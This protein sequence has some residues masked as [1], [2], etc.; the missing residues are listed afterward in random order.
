MALSIGLILILG[1]L[2]GYLL[3]KIKIPGLTGMIIIGMLIGPYCLSLIDPSVLSIS[4]ELRQIA[5]IIILT[6]SGLNLDLDSLR[7]IGRPAIL[8]SFVPATLEILGVALVG[9][10]LLDI[11]IFE[12]I[13]LGT[14]LAAV[15]PAV[16]SP[17]MIKLIDEGYGD[18]HNTPKLILAGSSID[19]IYVIVLFYTFFGLVENNRFDVL[20]ISMIPVTIILGIAL[21]II[22][23]IVLSFILRKTNFTTAV[24]TLIVFSSS[25]LMVGLEAILKNYISIS[26]LLG[27]IVVGIIILFKNKEKAKSLSKAY[28]SLWLFFEIILFV[29]VGASVDFSYALDNSL[30]AILI[31]AVGLIFRSLGVLICLIKTNLNFKE[32]LFC[33]ISY[34]PKATVQASIGG[35]ALALNLSCG[36]IILTLAVTSILITAPIGAILIDNLSKKLLTNKLNN[37]QSV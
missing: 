14:V 2:I 19:D 26:A 23:G 3:S 17:R 30:K 22:V 24:N 16:V 32:R 20:T 27:I 18:E 11:T 29:L 7:K 15:S 6:R 33:I 12:A 36:G 4:K 35:I 5:L 1:F 10:F 9:V 37:E 34:L 25:L 13:L 8:M 31:L 28:N 21:G